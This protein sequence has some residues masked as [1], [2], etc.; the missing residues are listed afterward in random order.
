MDQLLPFGIN[1]ETVITLMAGVAAFTAVI[2]V[3]NA[4]LTRDPMRGRLKILQA[5]RDALKSGYIAPRK[6]QRSPRQIKS[7]GLMRKLVSRLHLLRSEQARK[8]ADKLAEAGWRGKD[9]VVIFLFFKVVLPVAA[10]VV[11]IIFLYGLGVTELSPIAR[12][13][14]AMGLVL[15]GMVSPDMFVRNAIVKR[16]DEIRKSTPDALDLLVICAEAGLTLDAALNRVSREMGQSFSEIADEFSLTAIELGFLPERRQALANLAKRVNV[17]AIRSVVATLSQTEK[18][19]TP[20]A[21]SLRVLA[22]EF[23][24]ERLLKAEE[25]AARLPAI[26]TIPLIVFILPALF[27]VLIGPAALNIMDQF[28]KF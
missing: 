6:R 25:K 26:L 28:S 21:Q 17:P 14:V 3:W 23:R 10:G 12:L 9:T 22:D 7:V 11:A 20:L 13:L 27:V 8:T 19:G 24:T 15:A 4:A 5:R 16:Q 18:Y 1:F 2:A